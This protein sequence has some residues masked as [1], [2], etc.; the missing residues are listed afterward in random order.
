MTV[1]AL[2]QFLPSFRVSKWPSCQHF[3]NYDYQKIER[4]FVLNF[5][6]YSKT[7]KQFLGFWLLYIFKCW[8]FCRPRS[9]WRRADKEHFWKFPMF[10]SIPNTFAWDSLQVIYQLCAIALVDT[11]DSQGSVTQKPVLRYPPDKSLSLPLKNP[12]LQLIS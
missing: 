8:T 1:Y 7:F 12:F 4:L 10:A 6:S 3:W 2:K 5:C 9:S 11:S